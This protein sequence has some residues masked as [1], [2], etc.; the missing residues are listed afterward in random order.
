MPQSLPQ[1][2][3]VIGDGRDEFALKT[4]PNPKK[5]AK[6]EI[7]HMP[8]EKRAKQEYDPLDVRAVRKRFLAINR[9]RL[10]RTAGALSWRT[11][12]FLDL[13][14]LMFHINHAMLPGFVSKQTPAGISNW[15]P[16]KKSLEAGKRIAKSFDYKKRA[17]RTY[18]IHS[19]F[20]MGSVGTIAHS[21]KSD[22]DVWVCHRPG[23]GKEQL[24]QL[25]GKCEAIEEWAA[26]VGLEVHFFLMD[27]E[28]FRSGNVVELSSE[29]SGSTQHHLLL[30]EFYRTGILVAGRY[31]VW[32]LV[33][34]E[35]EKNYTKYV[36]RL[37]KQRFIPENEVI[38]FGGLSEIPAEEFFGAALW[39]VYKGIDS[40]YKSVLKMLLMEAYAAEY[41]RSDLLSLRYKRAIYAGI[42]DMDMLDPY[43]ILLEKLELYLMQQKSPERLD[44]VRRCF[45]FKVEMALSRQSKMNR[46]WRWE[47]MREL[48]EAWHWS[49]G[50]IEML[51]DRKSWNV[52]QVLKERRVLVDEITHSYMALSKFA[53][54][55]A[56]L[57]RIEQKD[58]NILG[59]KLYAAFE[60]KAGKIETINR[61][62]SANIVESNITII[63]SKAQDAE[64]SWSLY[65]GVVEGHEPGGSLKRAR[66]IV[67]VLAWCHFNRLVGPRT[68]ISLIL[69]DSVLDV[70]EVRAILDAMQSLFP[71]GHL[72]D[73][74]IENFNQPP[75]I[76]KGCLFANVGIDP[77][78]HH[79]RR[80][81]DLVSDQADVMNY[82]GFSLNLA[83]TFDVLVVTSWQEVITYKYTGIEGLL[84]C[85]AQYMHWNATGD[86]REPPELQAFSYSSSHS[87]AIAQRIE[88]LYKDLVDTF[89]IAGKGREARYILQVEK[90]YFLLESDGTT[91]SYGHYSSY[92]KL[93]EKLASPQDLFRPIKVDRHALLNTPLPSILGKNR[94]GFIQM[95]YYC[96]GEEVDVFVLDE[97]GSLFHQRVPYFEDDALV[98]HYSRFFDAVLNRQSFLFQDEN[99]GLLLDALEIH[100]VKKRRASKYS[101]ERKTPDAKRPA[102][103]FDVQVIGDLVDHSAAFTVYCNDREF[104]TM[105][106]GKNL[107]REVVRYVLQQ[108][109]GG[110]RYPI[111]IT[112]VD[113][114]P[115]LLGARRSDR[116]QA[117]DYLKYKKRIEEKMNRELARL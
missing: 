49:E 17:L 3:E 67:E 62:I 115:T 109:S 38:D 57:A 70:K 47:R 11:R 100:K 37:L 97:N 56:D 84:D 80:G 43:T 105:D 22:F 5:Q 68:I 113:L 117:I 61:G 46:N 27:A 21:E 106:Y 4:I 69:K 30:E 18:D 26:T 1:D 55:N 110:Q 103:Y 102:H 87:R 28:K 81:T 111:Y 82:S 35:E 36:A 33:P 16:T 85:F 44:V 34:P 83:L 112:D 86:V 2:A 58:L 104:S 98:N 94:T 50:H 89:F 60:R 76:E 79:S 78:P 74:E 75:L 12:D 13:L 90:A 31:P 63:Q 73:A 24:W 29:S 48:A 116:V 52:H 114:S 66:S 101:F 88:E 20:L 8:A 51:D 42:T 95:F 65:P 91:F 59:R 93:L 40:P 99:A 41:P 92:E 10:R 64:E 6:S 15:A 39:Q 96:L 53:R 72:Q 9:E 14:P 77:L 23:L 108:R 45:Y 19:V 54:S 107:F 25:A 7:E 71:E 32:W